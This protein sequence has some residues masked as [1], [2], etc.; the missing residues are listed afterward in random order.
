MRIIFAVLTVMMAAWP[1]SN[2]SADQPA[3]DQSP[4]TVAAPK[5]TK[6]QSVAA[7]V[8]TD[9]DRYPAGQT[10]EIAFVVTNT[11]K[12]PINYAYPSAQQYD[13]SIA[14][15]TGKEVWR[16]S[17][18]RVFGQAITHLDLRPGQST[19]Y[20]V[21][22]N[23]R[24]SDQHPIMPGTYTITASTTPTSRPVVTGSVLTNMNPDPANM[25]VPTQ[26]RV[27]TGGIQENDATPPVT[28][29]TTIV[30]VPSAS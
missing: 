27:Q 11:S 20:N 23:Q 1:V 5:I 9:A 7:V 21:P 8:K 3:T 4:L 12:S 14:D 6:A 26:D 25:G 29:K 19:T 28:A 13:V 17:K 16:W 22:W 15:A 18:S 2:A 10:V 24:D 30:I